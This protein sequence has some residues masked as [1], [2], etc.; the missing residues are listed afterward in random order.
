MM[1]VRIKICGIT[2]T[3]DGLAAVEAGA[4]ALG[5]MFWEASPRR[6]G[7]ETAAR[8]A[9]ALPPFVARVGVFVD[10]AEPIIREA[11][12]ACGLDVLQFHGSEPPEFCLRFGRACIKA[13]RVRDRDSL[14]VHRRLRRIIYHG[15]GPEATEIAG[16]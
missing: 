5:F 14:A 15:R 12:A 8:I 10:A 7:L 13:I 6:V 11:I 4:D 9:R 2:N 16:R 1:Q 3:E